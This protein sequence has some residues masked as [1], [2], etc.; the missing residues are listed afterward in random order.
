[1]CKSSILN[2]HIHLYIYTC[3]LFLAQHS[4]SDD[5]PKKKALKVEPGANQKRKCLKTKGYFFNNVFV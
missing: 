2:S 5:E 4:D 1:M 3:I